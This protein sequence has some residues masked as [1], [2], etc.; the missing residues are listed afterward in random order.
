MFDKLDHCGGKQASAFS[1]VE[2][3]IIVII[4]I[5]ITENRKTYVI[6]YLD[7]HMCQERKNSTH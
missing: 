2:P 6:V 7:M 3:K 1:N 4:I 5:I